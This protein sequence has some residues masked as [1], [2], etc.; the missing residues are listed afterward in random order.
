MFKNA[1]AVTNHK[2]IRTTVISLKI[3]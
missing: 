3:M 2:A 1:F